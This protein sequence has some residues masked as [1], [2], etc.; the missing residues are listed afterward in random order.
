MCSRRSCRQQQAPST[1]WIPW[2][3]ACW[4]ARLRCLPR[5]DPPPLAPCRALNS[6]PV[7]K[8]RV[9]VLGQD[10]YHGL[11]QA[12]GLSFSVPQARAAG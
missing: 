2:V 10:P 1:Q 6:V 5:F 12:M 11:G 8:V 9:V 4:G 3:W 7:D